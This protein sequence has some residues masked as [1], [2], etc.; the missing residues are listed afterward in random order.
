MAGPLP[1]VPGRALWGCLDLRTPTA[2]AA[3]VVSQFPQGHLLV[4]P[5]V[6]HSVLTV[7]PSGCARTAVEI[8]LDGGTLPTRCPRARPY[9]ANVPRIPLSVAKAPV[10]RGSSGLDGR[11]LSVVETTV[12]DA[13]AAGLISGGPIGG[14][15]SGSASAAF[16]SLVLERYGEVSGLSVCGTLSV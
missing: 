16:S 15:A 7:D 1:I 11:T 8:W 4:V 14:L 9:V 10:A 6:G 3:S 12:Q 13:L 5:G 2:V